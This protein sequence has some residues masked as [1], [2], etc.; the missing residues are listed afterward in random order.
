MKFV[1][2]KITK[3]FASLQVC[4]KTAMTSFRRFSWW[5]YYYVAQ[6]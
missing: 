5:H 1:T 3:S 2:K 4:I 6:V